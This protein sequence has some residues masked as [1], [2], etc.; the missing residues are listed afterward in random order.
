MSPRF[1]PYDSKWSSVRVRP[2]ISPHSWFERL[3][4]K[5]YKLKDTGSDRYQNSFVPQTNCTQVLY[6]LPLS[7]LSLF[8]KACSNPEFVILYFKNGRGRDHYLGEFSPVKIVR[9]KNRAWLMLHRL[10]AQDDRTSAQFRYEVNNRRHSAEK[11][12]E[13]DIKRLCPG[14]V[15]AFEPECVLNFNQPV[16]IDGR[17]NAWQGGGSEYTV[18]FI[19]SDSTSRRICFESK[20]HADRFDAQAE[21]KCRA[22]RDHSHTRVIAVHGLGEKLCWVDFGAPFSTA[23]PR[24]YGRNEEDDL[25]KQIF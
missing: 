1:A 18:D 17:E 25:R 21:Q 20:A 23:P 3:T 2:G 16:V 14:W 5:R 10:S 19:A 7:S 22:L 13:E 11:A 15:V 24:T 6:E 8:E 4:E 9:E 12:H